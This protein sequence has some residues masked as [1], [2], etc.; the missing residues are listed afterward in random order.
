MEQ[1]LLLVGILVLVAALFWLPLKRVRTVL[2][3]DHLVSTGHAFL[4]LGYGLGLALGEQPSGMVEDVA[5]IVA[6]VAGWIGFASGMRF[7]LRVLGTVPRRAFVVGLLPAVAAALLVGGTSLAVIVRSI[8]WTDR[9]VAGALV[10]A[11]AAA[12]SGPTLAAVV[13][14]RRAGRSVR[15]RSTLRLVEFSA[16]IDD[17]LV[18]ALAL[19]AF[20]LFR[21]D[22]EPFAVGWLLAMGVFGGA[23]LGAVTWLFLGGHATHDERLLLGLAML[24]FTAGFAAWLH[25]SPAAVAAIAG[26]VLVNMPGDRMEQLRLVVRRVERPAVGFVM[27]AIGFHLTGAIGWMFLPFVVGMTILRYA[28]K[29]VTGELVAGP[30]EGAPG[31]RASPSWAAGLTSQGTFGL[32]VAVSFLHVW[33]DDFARTV[34][35]AAAVGSLV[36]ELF[37]PALM[38]H[39]LRKTARDRFGREAA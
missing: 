11:A 34:L 39:V 10:L 19:V 24:G 14:A 28:V 3:L 25:L 35:A 16:G 8:G 5:P 26:I 18:I 2:G 12:S 22:V 21:A 32:M 23:L 17:L 15:A 30:I 6:F 7:D 27:I 4:V 29:H 13:R 1:G 33:R 38:L 31:L 20:A 36:N 37:A 9:G